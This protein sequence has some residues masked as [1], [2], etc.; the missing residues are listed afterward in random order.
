MRIQLKLKYQNV[1]I[2]IIILH[3]TNNLNINQYFKL[4]TKTVK[5]SAKHFFDFLTGVSGKNLFM[6]LLNYYTYLLQSEPYTSISIS[7]ICITRNVYKWQ[8]AV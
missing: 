5:I 2:A 7:L 8:S 4:K 1:K 3:Y 6:N